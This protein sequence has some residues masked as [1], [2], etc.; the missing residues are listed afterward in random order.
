MLKR[1]ERKR[2]IWGPSSLDAIASIAE[3][4]QNVPVH[5]LGSMPLSQKNPV[6]DLRGNAVGQVTVDF[7]TKKGQNNNIVA[8]GQ[9]MIGRC[10]FVKATRPFIFYK[11]SK[12]T[13]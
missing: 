12:L 6:A 9:R 7:V 4:G 5:I 3:K 13:L 11:L 2:Q 1:I 8:F 10:S